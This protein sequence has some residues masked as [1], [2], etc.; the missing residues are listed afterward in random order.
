M[1][2]PHQGRPLAT[3]FNDIPMDF[4]HPNYQQQMQKQYQHQQMVGNS[5]NIGQNPNANFKPISDQQLAQ[6]QAMHN[7]QM[8]QLAMANQNMKQDMQVMGNINDYDNQVFFY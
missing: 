4:Q 8:N 2:N 5:Y 7:F 6:Q 1:Q 3:N